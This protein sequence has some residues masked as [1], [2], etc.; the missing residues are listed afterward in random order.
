M[1]QIV[2]KTACPKC[3]E[4]GGDTQ[5][6]NL[7]VY[8]DGVKCFACGY[9]NTNSSSE[10]T[11]KK[12]KLNLIDNGVYK[13][14]EPRGIS[15]KVCEFAGYQ[16]GKDHKGTV[17]I[18]NYMDD[19]GN[20]VAQKLRGA[21]KRMTILGEADQMGLYLQWKFPPSE[22][23][24]IT[25]VE[26]E[27]DALSV[28][29]ADNGRDHFPV[30]SVP[31][32]AQGAKKALEKNLEYLSGFKYVVLGF[33]NDDS[34]RAAAKECAELFAPGKVRIATWPRKDP[35]DSLVAGRPQEIRKAFWAAKEIRPDG[36]IRGC[37]LD[38]EDVLTPLPKGV[39]I[40]YPQLDQMM[41]GLHKGRITLLTAHSKAGKSTLVK[42]LAFHLLTKQK[43]RIGNIF[44]EE[45][46]NSTILSYIALKY[47]VPLWKVMENPQAYVDPANPPEEL[48]TDGVIFHKHFGSLES[49]NLL[50]KIEHM[51]VA[52][53]MDFIILDH[54]SI[55]ISGMESSREGERKDIDRLMTAL[56]SLVERT[57]VGIIA[58]SHIKKIDDNKKISMNDLRGSGSLAQLSDFI[59]AVENSEDNVRLLRILGNR[60]TGEIGDA[61]YVQYHTDTGRLLP[62]TPPEFDNEAVI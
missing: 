28:L 20:I 25:V 40:P 31:N 4:Q 46:Q 55:V 59:I 2:K 17:H 21:G 39:P 41:R 15:K 53:K 29:E 10:T 50:K 51:A 56:R 9:N 19:Y 35:N 26:G 54:I 42:E 60:Y 3:R 33:D 22:K 27:I 30:V 57:G 43:A 44:L 1:G 18:A 58:I 62:T 24:S 36:L 23:L 34:G 45:S 11:T 7:V 6:D 48:N 32:G 5:G 12:R 8:T 61:D 14:L 37:E 49:N 47:N 38:W 16:V 13:D 52:D